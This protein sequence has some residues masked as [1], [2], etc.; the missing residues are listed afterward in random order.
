M[1]DTVFSGK[2]MQIE[3]GIIPFAHE[4]RIVINLLNAVIAWLRVYVCLEAIGLWL[5]KPTK[6][7]E[8]KNRSKRDGEMGTAAYVH[9]CV[10]DRD[11][12]NARMHVASICSINL[13]F[14][15]TSS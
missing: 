15:H 12:N 4:Y 14:N 6:A 7:D 8:R 2:G 13:Q 5:Q 9:V 3:S 1:H 10:N 11:S